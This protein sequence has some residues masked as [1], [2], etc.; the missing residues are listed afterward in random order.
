MRPANGACIEDKSD[1][2]KK[3]SIVHSHRGMMRGWYE[4]NPSS[5]EI[6]NGLKPLNWRKVFNSDQL[7]TATIH[8]GFPR[9]AELENGHIAF[10]S[11]S[12]LTIYNPASPDSKMLHAFTNQADYGDGTLEYDPHRKIIW[13]LHEKALLGFDV[14]NGQMIKG[15]EA[16]VKHGK[17]LALDSK[18]HLFSWDGTSKIFTLAP[19]KEPAYWKEFD[20]AEKGPQSGDGRVYGK[21]VYLKEHDI[22]VGLASHKTGVWVYKHSDL[23]EETSY[24]N[25]NPQALIDKTPAGGS[26]TI[27]PGIY[28]QGLL[29]NKSMTLKL[30]G[31]SL[32]GVAA[33]KG[34]I[35]VNCNGCK[36]ILEDFHTNGRKANCFWGNCA[37]IKAE[38][39]NFNLKVVRAHIDNTVIGIL[40]DNR[41]GTLILEDSLIENTGW[42]G[43]TNTLGHG[44]Y[45]GNIDKVIIRNSTIKRSFNDGHLVKSR[46]K[47]TSITNSI[48]A[49][50]DGFHSRV[51]D[52]PCGGQLEIKNSVLQQGEN[53]DNT[54]MISVETEP[55]SCQKLSQPTTLSIT[56]SWIIFDRDSSA[57]E[58]SANYG[59]NRLLTWR[60]SQFS[61]NLSGNNIIESTGKFKIDEKNQ[62]SNIR[63]KNQF[64]KNRS[65]AGLSAT[66][67]PT[68]L[69]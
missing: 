48:I 50:L 12:N 45:A 57:D 46:A 25:I 7:R 39:I 52:F 66:E 27:P 54:D 13:S 10:G 17:S 62:A 38:G 4:F 47:E 42:K 44:F 61:A 9:S 20:W 11:S 51:I 8:R 1:T 5:I 31:V 63:I 19:D 58:R 28:G 41:G 60:A 43:E 53:T 34:V 24:S 55:D 23:L 67:I 40:T 69:N 29:I 22:F 15:I 16:Q 6:I 64:Y 36:V 2:Y 68:H 35:N 21:W 14:N 49:G 37:G 26:L 32:R 65:A 56:K 30:N 18:G 3:S 33:S 59:N